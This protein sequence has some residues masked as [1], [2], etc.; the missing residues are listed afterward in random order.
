V[1]GEG[2]CSLQQ[3]ILIDSN[4]LKKNISSRKEFSSTILSLF[5]AKIDIL[6]VKLIEK[7]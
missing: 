2:N 6:G 5:D 4:C 7:L 1:L 3:E